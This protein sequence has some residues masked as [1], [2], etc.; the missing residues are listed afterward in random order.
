MR[1]IHGTVSAV[2]TVNHK[3]VE[4]ATMT[5][6]GKNRPTGTYDGSSNN[7]ETHGTSIVIQQMKEHEI[8]DDINRIVKDRDNKSGKLLDEV[9]VI[10][11]I[12]TILDITGKILKKL[13]IKWF[14]KTEIFLISMMKVN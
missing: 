5:K 14:K 2:D 11:L 1:G 8:F 7:M 12:V 3:V 9:G 4:F 13:S 6:K 10:D